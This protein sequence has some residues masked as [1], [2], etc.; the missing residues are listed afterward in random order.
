[1]DQPL[2]NGPTD[3]SGAH[4]GPAP[5]TLARSILELLQA[6]P[7]RYVSFGP[8]WPLVKV[9]LKKFYDQRNLSLLGPTTMADVAEHMPRHDSLQEALSAA[10][11]FYN[12]HQAY[13]LGQ[14]EFVDDGGNPWTLADPDAG[15]L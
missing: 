7:A 6:D 10:I 14:A 8:Y 3:A 9:L 1:M 2:P 12:D 13:G 5:A 15:G 11:E 4:S